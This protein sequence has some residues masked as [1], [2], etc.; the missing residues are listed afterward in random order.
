MTPRKFLYNW[1]TEDV[2]FSATTPWIAF[3]STN[4]SK[5]D[6]YVSDVPV[7]VLGCASQRFLCNPQTPESA[8]VNSLSKAKS[9]HAIQKA[10]SNPRDQ[11][12]I[13]PLLAASYLHGRAG[14][15]NPEALYSM[16]AAP[17]L[18]ARNTLMKEYQTGLLSPDHWKT[19][20]Q[21][22]FVASLAAWQSSL[23]NYTRGAWYGPSSCSEEFPCE[24][25][26]HSQVGIPFDAMEHI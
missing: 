20:R 21:Y 11:H 19:E 16:S 26:C 4:S 22:L 5:P 17:T 18:L 25:V 12:Q 9:V 1:E 15:G 2:W 8:C 7:S 3:G 24:R 6:G 13:Y 14:K 10:W 23:V